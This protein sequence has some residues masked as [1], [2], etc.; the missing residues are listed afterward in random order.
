[1][2][3]RTYKKQFKNPY[4]VNIDFETEEEKEE[5]L[6]IM[7]ILNRD[8]GKRYDVIKNAVKMMYKNMV[9]V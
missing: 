8:G 3:K 7:D 6:T 2:S 1:M 5:F 4:F 9:E